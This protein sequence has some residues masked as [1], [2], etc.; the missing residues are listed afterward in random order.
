MDAGTDAVSM[1]KG[2]DVPLRLGYIGVKN[3]SQ[4]QVEDHLSMEEARNEETTFFSAHPKYSALCRTY[5]GT[6]SLVDRLTDVL[7]KHLRSYLPDI[8][9]EI[10]DKI[11]RAE[12]R[13]R[14]LGYEVPV[15]DSDKL[16][17]M[18]SLISE[19]VDTFKNTMDGKHD[20]RIWSS[21]DLQTK[22]L[23]SGFR[24]RMVFND[25]L[26][27]YTDRKVTKDITDLKMDQA[28]RIYEGLALPGFPS[29]HTFR[30][31]LSSHLNAILPP[32]H[33][34]LEKSANIMEKLAIK[35]SKKVL[36]RFPDLAQQVTEQFGE[37]LNREKNKTKNLLDVFVDVRTT[38]LFTNDPDY[39]LEHG[40][41]IGMPQPKLEANEN[42]LLGPV[43]N[44]KPSTNHPILNPSKK[45]R[46]VY[47]EKFLSELRGRLDA[48]FWVIIR[49][50][51]DM[52]PSTI[53]RCLIDEIIRNLF[54][55]IYHALTAPEKLSNM[56]SEPPQRAEER[57]EWM[58]QTEVLKRALQVLQKDPNMS[59]FAATAEENDLDE[60][61][62]TVGAC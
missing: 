20:M 24:L 46:T 48:Y 16:R 41:M 39:I 5:V 18:S 21:S 57:R 59:D 43:E 1:L 50:V 37:I 44:T 8:K 22:E 9:K 40:S 42:N 30:S 61:L 38:Y 28:I 2:E 11:Y 45:P 54:I 4:Q 25:L 36:R 26:I 19:F 33:E 52:V 49:N 29:V 31:L 17:L 53:G 62:N 23:Q 14:E 3:R 10:T 55:E 34:C 56:L 47:G 12:S 27:D 7:F 51:R 35:V 32:V 58:K 15:T 6:K 13:L 60:D